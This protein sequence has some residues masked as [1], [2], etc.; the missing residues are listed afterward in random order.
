MKE[1]LLSMKAKSYLR[2]I[3]R[4]EEFIKKCK[5][6]ITVARKQMRQDKQELSK[7]LKR[8]EEWST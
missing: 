4:N 6:F 3:K 2:G 5:K 8:L 7:T 1:W